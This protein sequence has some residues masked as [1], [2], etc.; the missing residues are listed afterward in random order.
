MKCPSCT[1]KLR[2]PDYALNNADTYHQ[3]CLV[4]AECCGRMVTIRPTRSYIVEIYSGERKEDDWGV[5]V[6]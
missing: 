2:V 6:K 3:S 5:N 1:N 4:R